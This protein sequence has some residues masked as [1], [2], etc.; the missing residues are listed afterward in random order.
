MRSSFHFISGDVKL[1]RIEKFFYRN[2]Y[3]LERLLNVRPTNLKFEIYKP[4]FEKDRYISAFGEQA[5]DMSSSR[6]LS[7]N[8]LLDYGG[9]AFSKERSIVDL[10]CGGGRYAGF[11]EQAFGYRSYAEYDIQPSLE[12]EG[13]ANHLT[14]F[15]TTELGMD[16]VNIIDAEVIIS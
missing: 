16:K 13:R 15:H 1:S 14:R 12:W 5:L 9:E 2:S 11:I 6:V 7:L 8:F 4:S 10:G 3:Y